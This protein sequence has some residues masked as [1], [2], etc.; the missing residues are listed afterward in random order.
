[1]SMIAR[2]LLVLCALL[3]HAVHAIGETPAQAHAE[4]Q[5]K[6]KLVTIHVKD[7]DP[8]ELAQRLQEQSSLRVENM[9][10]LKG[11]P[12]IGFQFD[13][14]PLLTVLDLLA[15]NAEVWLH[16]EAGRRCRFGTR[17]EKIGRAH[18]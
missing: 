4:L 3:A 18:V 11:T 2:S 7:R 16:C 13:E 6:G 15:E 9:E 17:E 1:M 12:A 10:V 8:F 14:I 5:V